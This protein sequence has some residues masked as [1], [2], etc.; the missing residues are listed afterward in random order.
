MAKINMDGTLAPPLREGDLGVDPFEDKDFSCGAEAKVVFWVSTPTARRQD[1]FRIMQKIGD[2]INRI[3]ADEWV[4][5]SEGAQWFDL[6]EPPYLEEVKTIA[7]Q[8]VVQC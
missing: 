5:T 2:E 8:S 6:A 1:F 7:D 4:T 3:L